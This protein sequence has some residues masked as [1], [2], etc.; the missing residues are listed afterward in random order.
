VAR[1]VFE[2]APAGRRY[3]LADGVTHPLIRRAAGLWVRDALAE[4]TARH[5][6]PAHLLVGETPLVGHR[7]VELAR[8]VDDRA[9]PLLASPACRFV[10]AAP[11][12]EVREF[13]EAQ[14]E[15]RAAEPLHP[16]EREDAPPHVLRD[17]WRSVAAIAGHGAPAYDPAVYAGVYERILRHRHTETVALDVILPTERLSVYDYAVSPRDLVPTADDAERFILEVEHRYPDLRTLD[18]E[19]TRW[20]DT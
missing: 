2:A 3:P 10:I 11:S 5:R 6:E 15:R 18:D 14:L 17:L 13:L 9:E 7:F 4:W 8:R 20:W 12:R 1:P 16:R 19:I